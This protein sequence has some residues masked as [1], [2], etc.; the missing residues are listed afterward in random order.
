M[1]S[2]MSDTTAPTREEET[3]LDLPIE[4]ATWL[5]EN[6]PNQTPRVSQYVDLHGPGHFGAAWVIAT[7][8]TSPA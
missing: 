5:R 6:L 2:T 8:P 3:A 7:D 1:D 4:I